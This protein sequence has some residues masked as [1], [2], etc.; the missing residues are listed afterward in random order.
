MPKIKLLLTLF[1]FQL[2]PACSPHPGSGQ[3]HNIDTGDNE[4]VLIDVMF[5]GKAQMYGSDKKQIIRR[6]FWA[7]QDRN[8]IGLT[9]VHPDNTDTDISYQLQVSGAQAVLKQADQT[10]GNFRKQ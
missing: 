5:D 8:T 10:I 3:W 4:I 7:G 6:C 1:I 9:C 2:L